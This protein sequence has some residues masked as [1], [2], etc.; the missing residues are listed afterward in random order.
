MTIRPITLR[1]WLVRAALDGKLSLIVVPLK[2]QPSEGA[3]IDRDQVFFEYESTLD[4]VIPPYAPGDLL[5]ARETWWRGEYDFT[6][7]DPKG[8]P[9]EASLFY[10][11]VGVRRISWKSPVTMPR[12]ASRMT[13]RVRSVAVKRVQDIT[14]DEAIDTGAYST[15]ETFVECFGPAA[16]DANPWCA[17][18]AVEV[19]NK[20]VGEVK[21]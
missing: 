4:L 5:W 1:D 13:L 10:R 6:P 8:T 12:W 14:A 9:P 7:D 3:T 21:R 19:I 11:A 2:W 17:F 15:N 18:V 20:N 16:W